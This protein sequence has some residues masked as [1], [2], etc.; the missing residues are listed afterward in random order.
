M[1]GDRQY[2]TWHLDGRSW[3]RV[4]GLA[5]HIYRASAVSGRDIWAVSAGRRSDVILRYDGS[6][7]HRIHSGT[8]LAGVRAHDILAMSAHDVWVL[9]NT[10]SRNGAG[11]VVL[12]HW[13]GERWTRLETKTQ[14]WACRLAPG[15]RGS[16]LIT[17]TPDGPAATG[18]I[19]QASA[20]RWISSITVRSAQG[21]GVTDIAVLTG[22]RIVLATG[23]VLTSLGGDA[24]IW[25]GQLAVASRLDDDS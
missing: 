23:G 3:H 5:G 22:S 19:L 25:E 20:R 15:W 6:R 16:V 2:G 12:A 4:S 18:L 17:A 21:S 14:A 7:W 24:A 11:R 8:A 13:N 10:S 1:T 9:G